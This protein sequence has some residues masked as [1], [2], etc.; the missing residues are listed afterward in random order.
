MRRDELHRWRSR[1]GWAIAVGLLGGLGLAGYAVFWGAVNGLGMMGCGGSSGCEQRM[2]AAGAHDE[3]LFLIA[4]IG[5]G[6]LLVAGIAGRILFGKRLRA[7]GP[8]PLPVATV[9]PRP[10]SGRDVP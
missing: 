6:G 1:A 8:T 10:D 5:G 4:L 2:E 9:V 7:L 3:R